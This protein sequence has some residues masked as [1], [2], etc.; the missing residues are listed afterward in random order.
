MKLLKKLKPM[1]SKEFFRLMINPFTRG[2]GWQAFVLG[3]VFLCISGIIGTYGN[4]IFDGVI[5]MHLTKGTTMLY[6]FGC[7]AINT[8][9]LVL[10]M[11]IA[12]LVISKGFRFIDILGTMTLSKAPFLLLAIAGFF[13]KAPDMNEVMKNPMSILGSTS[14]LVLTLMTIPILIWSIT[15]MY[16]AL[17]ISC[18]VKGNKLTVAFII[19]ILISEA[20]SKTLILKFI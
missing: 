6:S 17:K 4:V 2:A 5:D 11:W 18:G 7:L 16:N 12:G 8:L 13:T 10:V 15:L 19:A 14:F 20:I 1:K 9:T 3:L